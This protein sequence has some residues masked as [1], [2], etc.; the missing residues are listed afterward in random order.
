M[1]RRGVIVQR[2]LAAILYADVAG[3]TRLMHAD[4][5]GTLRLLSAHREITDRLIA[6]HGGRI[7]NTAGDSIL[8][9]FAS[10][11]DALRCALEIQ[12]RID[13]ANEDVPQ[14]RRVRFRIGLHVG[15]AMV[16]NGDLF[17]DGVNIAARMQSLALPGAVCLSGTAYEFAHGSVPMTYQDLGPQT[18]RNLDVPVRAW[19]IRPEGRSVLRG[20]PAV[21][22]RIEFQLGR[23][24]QHILRTA[25]KEVTDPEGLIPEDPAM[26]ASLRDAPGI[27]AR[28]LAERIGLSLPRVRR[29]VVRIERR[30]LIERI[31]VEGG[32]RP[33]ALRLTSRG[34]QLFLRLRPHFLA[35][36]DR[37][38]APLSDAERETLR[39]LLVRVI[40]ANEGNAAEE[41]DEHGAAEAGGSDEPEPP[42][43]RDGRAA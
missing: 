24:F 38:M 39:E 15:E 9:E 6:Q 14:E 17:G 40:N 37:V 30:G 16:R 35:A 4:E 7:A 22:R 42:G 8:A 36:L 18:V 19:L 23:R 13:A 12:E 2:R 25:M 41:R 1:N 10:A 33:Q 3:Y 21:H 43:H 5:S 31:E 26:L 34:Q 11:V 32:A 28:R 27:D 20:I 29:M